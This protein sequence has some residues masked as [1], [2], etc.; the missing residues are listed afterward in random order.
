MQNRGEPRLVTTPAAMAFAIMAKAPEAGAVKTRLV[1]PLRSEE[2]A[3]LHASFLRDVAE[4][5]A[6]FASRQQID[7]LLVFT[8]PDRAAAF[9]GLLPAGFRLLAQ[10]GAGLSER[11]RYASEDGFAAGYAAITLVGADSPTLPLA[12]LEEAAR[13]LRA[14]GNRVVLGPAEDGGYY[15]IGLKR[16]EPRLFQGIAWSTAQVLEQTLARARE[17]ALETRLLPAWYDVDDPASLRR[18]CRAV[19]PGEDSPGPAASPAPHTREC[20]LRLLRGGLAERLGLPASAF[21]RD[22]S[23]AAP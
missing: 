14:P 20:L 23:R 15:L 2:A 3:A 10:R 21:G 13:L 18:L 22:T 1:P 12:A 16:A 7:P 4:Q 17:L 8:P 11:L 5:I 9:D 19:F 6:E